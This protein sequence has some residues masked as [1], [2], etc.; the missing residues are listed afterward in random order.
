MPTLSVVIPCKDDAGPLAACLKALARQ[1]IAPLQIIVVDNNS[2]DNSAAVATQ[3][4][5]LVIPEPR[6]GIA[7]AASTGYDAAQADII[8]RCDADSLPPRDWLERISKHFDV[9]P[10]LAVL[11]GPGHFHDTG[12]VRARI[13]AVGYMQA[14][15]LT[16]GAAMGHWPP[17][18]SNLAFRKDVW[19]SVRTRIHRW[20]TE[21]HDDVDLGFALDPSHR[22]EYDRTLTVGIS[23]RALRG[24]ADARR[25]FGRAVHTIALHWRRTP[26]WE[27]WRKSLGARSDRRRR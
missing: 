16:M 7:A 3:F 11:T 1:S 6:P 21:V 5:A 24:G 19:R 8:V 27:R 18:G 10:G 12:A 26:P 25:R 22:T 20:D 4:G 2:S 15:F 13:A 14:Y 17:F 23:A 9:D